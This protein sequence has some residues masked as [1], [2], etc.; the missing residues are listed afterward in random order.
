MAICKAPI[1][2]A[3][4]PVSCPMGGGHHLQVENLMSAVLPVPTPLLVF[5]IS[6]PSALG[7]VQQTSVLDFGL[8][9]KDALLEGLELSYGEADVWLGLIPAQAITLFEGLCLTIGCNNHAIELLELF[10]ALTKALKNL[11]AE[12]LEQAI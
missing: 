2:Y 8:A 5:N 3:S 10:T 6:R 12:L 4:N 11:W 7:L 1:R 9:F